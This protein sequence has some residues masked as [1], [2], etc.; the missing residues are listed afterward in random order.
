MARRTLSSTWRNFERLHRQYEKSGRANTDKLEEINV[1]VEKTNAS[2]IVD[3]LAT[4]F[5]YP[6]DLDGY[7]VQF[8]S[9]NGSGT[10]PD[11]KTSSCE[12]EQKIFINIDGIFAFMKECFQAAEGL[13]TPEARKS[14]QHYR[15]QA[16]L[17][18]LGKLPSKYILFLLL[19]REVAIL[20]KITHVE[21]KHG[22]V[23]IAHGKNYLEL[24]WAFKELEQFFRRTSGLDLRAEC[25]ILWLES[26][27]F[28]GK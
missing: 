12:D 24:L 19:L 16:Y 4:L 21:K 6:Y 27:W 7:D 17:A 14:F 25:G 9:S 22:G 23:E 18:E 26:D 11:W 20:R 5:V 3:A 15:F 13:Q 28:V 8:V 1:L 2:K 10:F